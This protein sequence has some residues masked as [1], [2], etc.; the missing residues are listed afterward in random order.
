V[1]PQFIDHRRG[2]KDEILELVF[3]QDA[4]ACGPVTNHPPSTST[5]TPRVALRR[6]NFSQ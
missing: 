3:A 1:T 6:S 5:S 2:T 4:E